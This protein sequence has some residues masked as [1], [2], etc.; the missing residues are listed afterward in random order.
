MERVSTKNMLF[1]NMEDKIWKCVAALF[2]LVCWAS[3]IS[4]IFYWIYLFSLNEDLTVI[5]YKR[6]YHDDSNKYPMLSLCFKNPFNNARL[7]EKS[8]KINASSYLEFLEGK[9]FQIDMSHYD[10]QNVINNISEYV[11]SY[12]SRWRN[13]TSQLF[14]INLFNFA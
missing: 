4:V 3:A 10:Y 8:T 11:V 9:H 5:D 2:H 13:S 1:K 12:W 7:E 14:K 6:Y